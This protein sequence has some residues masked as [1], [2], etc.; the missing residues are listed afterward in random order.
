M[1]T[2]FNRANFERTYGGAVG[3][4]VGLEPSSGT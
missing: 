1:A 2:T 4:L 3:Q